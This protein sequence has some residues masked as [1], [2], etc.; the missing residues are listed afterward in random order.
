MG[1]SVIG[2]NARRSAWFRKIGTDSHR[3]NAADAWSAQSACL[4]K[5]TLMRYPS[6]IDIWPDNQ[7]VSPSLYAR[8]TFGPLPNIE[9]LSS[10]SLLRPLHSVH[11]GQRKDF[12]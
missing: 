12:S 10:A 5:A 4:A 8:R 1:N 3:H 2:D 6:L 7:A 9:R 11:L